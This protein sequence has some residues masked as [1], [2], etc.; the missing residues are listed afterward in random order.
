MD[1]VLEEENPLKIEIQSSTKAAIGFKNNVGRPT[2]KNEILFS[3]PPKSIII[4]QLLHKEKKLKVKDDLNETNVC[5][6]E[7]VL[8]EKTVKPVKKWT[9]EYCSGRIFYKKSE[10]K[11]HFKTHTVYKCDYQ[12]CSYSTKFT[13]NLKTHKRIHTS[14]YPYVCDECTFR[15]KFI[16]SLKTHKRLHNRE[17]PFACQYCEYKCNSG[18]NLKK[19]CT[20]KHTK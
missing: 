7:N 11:K 8:A 9:C 12:N 6:H 4:S 14:D 18:S 17:L 2:K 13:S 15:T 20:R 10:Y 19:H 5:T 1:I 3:T 16:N